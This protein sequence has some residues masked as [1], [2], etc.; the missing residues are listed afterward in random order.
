MN[1]GTDFFGLKFTKQCLTCGAWGKNSVAF[2]RPVPSWFCL[3]KAVCWDSF[4]CIGLE[5]IWKLVQCNERLESLE[6]QKLNKRWRIVLFVDPRCVNAFMD[7]TSRVW[8]ST[9]EIPPHE[10]A[11]GVHKVQLIGQP[12]WKTCL[13][14]FIFLLPWQ[15][16]N[17]T[18]GKEREMELRQN[19]GMW[20]RGT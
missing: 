5:T 15:V 10:K 9:F 17:T 7:H 4:H 6:P 14:N 18:R 13:T 19:N 8:V 12:F 2:P 3:V 1:L 16:R 11:R 20:L